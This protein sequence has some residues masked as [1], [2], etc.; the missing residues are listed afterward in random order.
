M[1]VFNLGKLLIVSYTVHNILLA[2]S[3]FIVQVTLELC[4]IL[5]KLNIRDEFD[6]KYPV[7]ARS[8]IRYCKDTQIKS[9][10]LQL[11]TKDTEDKND[12]K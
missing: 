11:E 6:E 7:W 4:Y 12:G 2:L 10:S 3:K 8:I 5:K 1:E 9:T